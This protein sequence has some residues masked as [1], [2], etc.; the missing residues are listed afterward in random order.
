MPNH[1]VAPD[2]SRN[3]LTLG[4]ACAAG[5]VIVTCLAGLAVQAVVITAAFTKAATRS[6]EQQKTDDERATRFESA[7]E[8]M[9]EE[10]AAQGK[11]LAGMVGKL[12]AHGTLLDDVRERVTGIEVAERK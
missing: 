5:I 3:R 9:R 1:A 4:Q 2:L 7:L 10:Q 8:A 12:E 11:V 6:E